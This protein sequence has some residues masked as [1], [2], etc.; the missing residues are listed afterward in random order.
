VLYNAA[1]A[2]SAQE[3]RRHLLK[4]LLTGAWTF[5]DWLT[6]SKSA[7]WH[8]AEAAQGITAHALEFA[9]SL[10]LRYLRDVPEQCPSCGSPK[11]SP[12]E[13]FRDAIPGVLWER[14]TC[15][16]CGWACKPVPVAERDDEEDS[17]FTQVGKDDDKHVLPEVPLTTLKKPLGK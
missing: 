1:L 15:E 13:G 11:L 16:D 10:L 17:I 5:A 6:H 14:P 4:T 12:Q 8:D 7:T 9:T 3:E 2:G